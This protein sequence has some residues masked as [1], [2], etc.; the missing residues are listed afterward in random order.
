MGRE[1]RRGPIGAFATLFG[2]GKAWMGAWVAFTATAIM[3]YYSVVMGWTLRYLYG[4]VTRGIPMTSP[5][6]ATAFWDGYVGT[7]WAALTHAIAM[8]LGVYVVAKGV[9]GIER[10]ARVLIPGLFVLV[11]VLAVRAVTLPGAEAGLAFLFTPHWADLAEPRIWLEALTQNALGHGGRL[12]T[13]RRLRR[14][15]PENPKTR[16]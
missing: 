3:F 12:G 4:S 6:A 7:P 10:A 16:R 9:K 14:V 13:R 15:P 8:G 1:T 5:E 2:K 11:I